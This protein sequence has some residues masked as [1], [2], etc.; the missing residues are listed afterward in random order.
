MVLFLAQ[1][2]YQEATTV[3]V[4]ETQ[5]KYLA[6]ASEFIKRWLTTAP[7]PTPEIMSFYATILLQQA[8]A[9]PKTSIKNS[10]S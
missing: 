3:K 6:K 2:N 7:K 8:V 10:S 1:I 4:P 9:D 5:R